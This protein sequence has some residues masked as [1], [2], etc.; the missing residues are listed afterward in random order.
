MVIKAL[1]IE[2][3]RVQQKVHQLQDQLERA[4]GQE[5]D[6]LTRELRTAEAECNQLRRMVDAKKEPPLFRT[7]FKNR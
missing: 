3:Y 5:K 2:L 6:R 1:A 7:N 4:T